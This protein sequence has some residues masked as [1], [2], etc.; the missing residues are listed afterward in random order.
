MKCVDDKCN[1]VGD[2]SGL[3]SG[4]LS[5]CVP[6]ANLLG[7]YIAEN[8]AF[9]LKLLDFTGARSL[10]D[11]AIVNARAVIRQVLESKN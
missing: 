4:H 7:H 6:T 2:N 3:G 10:K 11:I 8:C 1:N 9:Y 5:N